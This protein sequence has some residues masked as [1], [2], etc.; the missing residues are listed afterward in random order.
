MQISYVLISFMIIT[1]VLSIIM[2]TSLTIARCPNGTHK[3]PSGDCEAVVSHEGLP[4]CPNDFHRSPGGNCEEVTSSPS[5]DDISS[6][7]TNFD[8]NDD[9][10]PSLSSSSSTSSSS[11]PTSSDQCDQSLW[12]HVYNPSRLQ[13]VDYC[14]IASGTIESVR[15][16]RDGDFHVRVKLD[17]QFS[18]LINSANVN[19][20]FGNLVVEPIC[21]NRV[22]QPSAILS[23]QDFHQN[24]E[25]PP[26][27][28][29]VEITGSYVLDKEHG[30]WAEIHPV[31]SITTIP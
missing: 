23:C 19:G 12:D 30:S 2:P 27:G 10:T 26:V 31:T 11:A 13:V 6:G 17:P 3:S 8:Q 4:R 18:N 21:V 9:S 14:R 25:V 1:L 16:E 20:Q 24:I 5:E 7:P 29:H 28:T 15:T 22:T